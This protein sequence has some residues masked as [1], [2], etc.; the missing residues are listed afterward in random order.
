MLSTQDGQEGQQTRANKLDRRNLHKSSSRWREKT[1]IPTPNTW[2]ASNKNIPTQHQVLQF[3]YLFVFPCP[4]HFCPAVVPVS[5][6]A[7]F[8]VCMQRS[9]AS[10]AILTVNQWLPNFWLTRNIDGTNVVSAIHLIEEIAFTNVV[11]MLLG[12]FCTSYWDIWEEIILLARSV[13]QKVTS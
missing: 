10:C 4:S 2:S 1:W 6:F 12:F 5:Y 8:K 11:G 9:T 3:K 7:S 13:S